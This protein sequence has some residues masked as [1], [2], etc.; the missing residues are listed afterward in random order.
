MENMSR[1]C[2]SHE[3]NN[4]SHKIETQLNQF[5]L[6]SHWFTPDFFN[7]NNLLIH[8]FPKKKLLLKRALSLLSSPISFHSPSNVW[9]Q[10]SFFRDHRDRS[11]TKFEEISMK[12]RWFVAAIYF[13]KLESPNEKNR[14]RFG[15]V[16]GNE[17]NNNV[18]PKSCCVPELNVTFSLST[19]WAFFYEG[20]N[21]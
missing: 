8:F 6:L 12:K 17:N 10:P 11:K 15:G 3:K 19:E 16:K 20:N 5:Q 13:R 14:R 18:D 21:S 7:W 9:A 4:F 2:T 1:K